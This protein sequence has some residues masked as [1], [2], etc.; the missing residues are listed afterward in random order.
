MVLLLSQPVL[1]NGLAWFLVVLSASQ[2]N[3]KATDFW[4]SVALIALSEKT[5]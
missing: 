5:I 4:E 3:K 1:Q 2:T